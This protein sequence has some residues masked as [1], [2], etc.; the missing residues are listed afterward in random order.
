MNQL[1]MYIRNNYQISQDWNLNKEQINDIVLNKLNSVKVIDWDFDIKKFKYLRKDCLKYDRM[2]QVLD[3]I[4]LIILPILLNNNIGEIYKIKGYDNI[5]ILD[6]M[7]SR[8]FFEFN[9]NKITVYEI[10]TGILT[11]PIRDN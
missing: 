7:Y 8:I 10:T 5:F 4:E 9:C 11:N 3:D 1:Q 2:K 6:D